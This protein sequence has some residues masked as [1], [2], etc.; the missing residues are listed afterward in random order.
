MYFSDT[1]EALER[2]RSFRVPRRQQWRCPPEDNSDAGG[3]YSRVFFPD[4]AQYRF[5]WALETWKP[6]TPG[7]ALNVAKGDFPAK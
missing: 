2:P 3:K 6:Q 4:P 1:G 5:D 7:K